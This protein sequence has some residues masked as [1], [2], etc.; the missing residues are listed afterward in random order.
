M[1]S[2]TVFIQ[3]ELS[4]SP[5]CWE[6]RTK[7]EQRSGKHLFSTPQV[8]TVNVQLGFGPVKQARRADSEPKNSVLYQLSGSFYLFTF[9]FLQHLF[10]ATLGGGG[11]IK[12][13]GH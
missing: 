12:D 10:K 4:D 1:K 3:T 7:M 13:Y 9:Y 8:V 5:C 2:F 11:V 6:S